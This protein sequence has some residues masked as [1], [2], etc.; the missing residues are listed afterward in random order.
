MTDAVDDGQW[1]LPQNSATNA[2]GDT[3]PA[4]EGRD[5]DWMPGELASAAFD[6]GVSLVR[7]WQ[8]NHLMRLMYG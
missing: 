7:L 3:E 1:L 8:Y 5:R 2:W 4:L 6:P